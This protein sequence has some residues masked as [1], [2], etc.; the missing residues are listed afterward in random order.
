MVEFLAGF[1]VGEGEVF[2]GGVGLAVG[3]GEAEEEEVGRGLTQEVGVGSLV[4]NV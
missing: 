3:E 2:V 4:A 1:E